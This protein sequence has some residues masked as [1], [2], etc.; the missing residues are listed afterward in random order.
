MLPTSI[1]PS[2]L[3]IFSDETFVAAD[4]RAELSRRVI[5]RS[6]LYKNT[7]RNPPDYIDG[8]Q[9]PACINRKKTH[10]TIDSADSILIR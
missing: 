5:L 9:L 8:T 7:E 2:S 4:F 3:P 1:S 6:Q 10:Y